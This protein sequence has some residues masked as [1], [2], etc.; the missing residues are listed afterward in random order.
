MLVVDVP[1]KRASSF[2]CPYACAV[3]GSSEVEAIIMCPGDRK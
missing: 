3:I 2:S 1:L